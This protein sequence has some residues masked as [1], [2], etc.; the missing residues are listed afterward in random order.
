[1][2]PKTPQGKQHRKPTTGQ[3][4]AKRVAW[5]RQWGALMSQHSK[6]YKRQ[7]G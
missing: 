5:G 6:T 2:A 4:Q 1:M 7:G 3:A